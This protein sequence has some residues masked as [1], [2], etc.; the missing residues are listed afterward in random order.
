M[1]LLFYIQVIIYRIVI[2]FSSIFF[3]IIICFFKFILLVPEEFRGAIMDDGLEK[4]I[5]SI[6][7]L[8]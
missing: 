4:I 5:Q 6:K 1:S 3:N 2:T 7:L 8:T